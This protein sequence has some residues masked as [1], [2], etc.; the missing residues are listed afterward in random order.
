MKRKDIYYK[1]EQIKRTDDYKIMYLDETEYTKLLKGLKEINMLAYKEILFKKHKFNTEPGKHELTLT[2]DDDF[3]RV[4]GDIKIIYSTYKDTIV[5]ENIEPSN[6]L[7]EYHRQRKNT[8][9]GIPFVNERD[10]FK[11]NLV[12]EMKKQ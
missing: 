2:T 6:V 8:Y 12:K 9:K 4:H 11:I 5:I 3:K 10:L 7:M 1:K